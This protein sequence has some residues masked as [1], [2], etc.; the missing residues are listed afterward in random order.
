MVQQAR[1]DTAERPTLTRRVVVEGA[2]NLADSAG[3]ETVTIRR[4]ARELGV[5][6]MALYWHFRSKN[7]LLAGMVDGIYEKVDPTVDPSATWPE[8]LR[9]LLESTVRA[10]AAH[11]SVATLFSGQAVPSENNLRVAEALLDIL[12]R[13]GFSPAEA[14]QI[15]RHALGT[16]AE[17]VTGAQATAP[18]EEPGELLDARQRSRLF[19]ESLPPEHYPRVVE[20][21]KPLSQCDDADTHHAFGLDLLLAGIETMAARKR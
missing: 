4:L 17:L 2:L 3:L 20:A 8:Q 19:L 12:R 21:A 15:A 7:E 9:T 13:A 16:I 5:T 18:A 14:T 11:P 1:R 6:P 10:L